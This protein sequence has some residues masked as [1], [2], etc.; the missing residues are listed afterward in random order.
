[1]ESVKAST[2]TFAE[3][4]SAEGE[5]LKESI[6]V[7]TAQAVSEAGPSVSAEAKPSETAPLVLEKEG[8]SEKSKSPAPRASAEEL[9]FIV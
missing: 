9:E 2:P 5:I 4:P 3:A 1:M 6:E 8:A 7:G